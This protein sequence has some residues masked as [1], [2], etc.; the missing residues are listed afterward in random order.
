MRGDFNCT[1]SHTHH[2]LLVSTSTSFSHSTDNS[3]DQYTQRSAWESS[4]AGVPCGGENEANGALGFNSNSDGGSSPVTQ[5][6]R[7]TH[8]T[9]HPSATLGT[10]AL[11]G[12][13]VHPPVHCRQ[14]LLRGQPCAHACATTRALATKTPHA[15]N[16][17]LHLGRIDG[18]ASKRI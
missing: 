10:P 15:S 12:C 13:G 5:S 9:A 3:T 8:P 2:V 1:M 7:C 16:E 17:I 4:C 18:D 11:A 6:P 14:C